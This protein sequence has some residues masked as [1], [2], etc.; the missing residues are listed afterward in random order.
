MADDKPEAPMIR[1]GGEWTPAH[2]VWKKMETAIVVADAIQRFNERFPELSTDETRTVVPLVRQRLKEIELRMPSRS[3][4]LPDLGPI[5]ADLLDSFPPE[6]ALEAL[7][8]RCGIQLDMQHMVQLAGQAYMAALSRE[9]SEYEANQILPE[10]TAQLWNNCGRPAPS[11]GLW[12]AH[13]VADLLDTLPGA[14]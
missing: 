10:Q 2:E 5:A 8:D 12:T 9:A 13:K 3:G 6:D 4:E 14:G 1:F 7:Q 11:G